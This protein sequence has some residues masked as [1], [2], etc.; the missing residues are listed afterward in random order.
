MKLSDLKRFHGYQS[1]FI[2]FASGH[3]FYLASWDAT[4]TSL[5]AFSNVWVVTPDNTRMLFADPSASSDIVRI[6]HAFDEVYGA[7]ISVQH[8]PDN[9]LRV[10]CVS[11]NGKHD[12]GFRLTLHETLASRLITALS[13]SPPTRLRV[14]KPALAISDFLVNLLVAGQGSRMYGKTETGM[15]YYHGATERL[16]TVTS[17]SARLDGTELGEVCSPT[18]DVEFGDSVPFAHPV[19]K[20]GSLHIPYDDEMLKRGATTNP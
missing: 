10:E 4:P 7:S 9:Q 20:I 8:E 6:Y 12:L 5:S 18:W 1:S 13:G 19:V 14:S 16:L 3:Y 17:G 15:P 2:P 11:D